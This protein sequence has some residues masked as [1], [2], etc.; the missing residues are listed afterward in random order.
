[1]L[2]ISSHLIASIIQYIST[3]AYST[4]E[5]TSTFICVCFKYVC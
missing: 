5:E 1:M 4:N 3:Y 2:F